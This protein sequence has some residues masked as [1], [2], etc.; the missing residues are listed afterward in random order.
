MRVQISKS[1]DIEAAHFLPKHK[2]KCK[3]LHGH[4]WN[5]T[6]A[7][8]CDSKKLVDGMVMDFSDLKQI[9]QNGVIDIFD[10]RSFNE[11][12]PR[13]MDPTS[14]NIALLIFNML[15]DTIEPRTDVVVEYVSLCE[16]QNS[17]CV[18]FRDRLNDE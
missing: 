12:L 14:E 5:L 10:H 9:V 6:V 8:S 16:T 7:V 2:G 1:F 17:E 11:T 13:E 3:K 18:V 4:R 15:A